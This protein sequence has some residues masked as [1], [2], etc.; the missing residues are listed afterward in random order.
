M[1]IV[2]FIMVTLMIYFNDVFFHIFEKNYYKIKNILFH[3]HN[4]KMAVTLWNV[5][6]SVNTIAG[7]H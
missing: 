1:Y 5:V 7:T 4:N 6:Y 2:T 3:F